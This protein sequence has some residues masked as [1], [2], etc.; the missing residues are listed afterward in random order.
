M[1]NVFSNE[2]CSLGGGEVTPVHCGTFGS[3]FTGDSTCL[4]LNFAIFF[5]C[6]V[7]ASLASILFTIVLISLP[8][9]SSSDCEEYRGDWLGVS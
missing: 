4:E 9:E 6:S 2:A 5:V 8:S 3:D 7:L 1:V